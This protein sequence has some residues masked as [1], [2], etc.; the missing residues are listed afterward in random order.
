MRCIIDREHGAIK[1]IQV[2]YIK[3]CD[4]ISVVMTSFIA[5]LPSQHAPC[6]MLEVSLN[7]H[8]SMLELEKHG[9]L[10]M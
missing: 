4:S 3:P 5:V 7:A 8:V 2:E 9:R 10:P 6:S 1:K